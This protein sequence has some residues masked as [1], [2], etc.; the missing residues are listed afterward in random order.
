MLTTKNGVHSVRLMT[1]AQSLSRTNQKHGIDLKMVCVG[2]SKTYSS[3]EFLTELTNCSRSRMLVLSKWDW[4]QPRRGTQAHDTLHTKGYG[5][6]S[7]VAEALCM[8]ESEKQN[9]HHNIFPKLWKAPS[10][11]LPFRGPSPHPLDA[12]GLVKAI[13]L[14]SDSN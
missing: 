5:E 9:K 12:V 8:C 11:L 2:F 14:F 6:W 7:V 13:L 3:S 10:F 4:T 1:N